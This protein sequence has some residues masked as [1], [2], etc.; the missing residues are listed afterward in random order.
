MWLWNLFGILCEYVD[1]NY[2]IVYGIVE[3]VIVKCEF[4]YFVVIYIIG[5]IYSINIELKNI[6]VDNF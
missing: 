5:N 1:I 2:L 4:K 3:N 6:I